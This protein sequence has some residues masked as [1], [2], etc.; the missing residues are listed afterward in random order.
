MLARPPDAQ[1]PCP[2]LS[3]QNTKQ[4][5]FTFQFDCRKN[6]S[7]REALHPL[8]LERPQRAATVLPESPPA[9]E[10]LL[11]PEEQERRPLSASPGTR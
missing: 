3:F 4:G 11:P 10:P 1:K 9:P 6:L 5:F 8:S 2:V 7:E